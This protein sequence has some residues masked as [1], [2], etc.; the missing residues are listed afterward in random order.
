YRVAPRVIRATGAK[1]SPTAAQPDG[2]NINHECGSTHLEMLRREVIRRGLD[3]GLALDGDADRLLAVDAK[4]GV[5]DGD[6]IIAILAQYRAQH[7]TLA[8]QGVVVSEW[9][10]LGLRKSLKGA[11]IEVAV[12][13]VGDKAVAEAMKR[14]GFVLGGEQ[15]GHVIMSDLLP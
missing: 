11:G 15:S 4:G 3:F 2:R 10:N 7:G 1:V 12:S 5:V 13:G 9:S 6:D 14:T 8:R